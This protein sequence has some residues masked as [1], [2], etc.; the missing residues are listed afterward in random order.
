MTKNLL[1]ALSLLA[2]CQERAGP[3]ISAEQKTAV[4]DT[5]RTMITSAY[6]LTKPGT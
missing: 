2:G 3:T 5:L 1:L 4:A 6:D